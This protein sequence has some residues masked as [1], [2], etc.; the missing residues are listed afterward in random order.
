MVVPARRP[1]P[2]R[3]APADIAGAEVD[4]LDL[5]DLGSVQAFAD[6]FLA[7]GRS[8]DSRSVIVA[9]LTGSGKGLTGSC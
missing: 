6:R 7:S 2:A 4:E 5:G 8:I 1:G 9:R 3:E